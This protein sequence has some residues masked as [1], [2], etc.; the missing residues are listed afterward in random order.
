MRVEGIPRELD[1]A[2]GR[3]PKTPLCT[4]GR[5]VTIQSRSLVGLPGVA[6]P[7]RGLPM[8]QLGRSLGAGLPRSSTD[9]ADPFGRPNR[10]AATRSA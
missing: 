6:R 2:P 9:H 10:G 7:W 5:P 8:D 3:T 1:E 4:L